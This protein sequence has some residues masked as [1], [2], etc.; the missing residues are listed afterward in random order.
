MQ[1]RGERRVSHF[2]SLKRDFGC[3]L[4]PKR[5][6]LEERKSARGRGMKR[7][8]GSVDAITLCSLGYANAL[9]T[10][11]KKKRSNERPPYTSP[12][13]YISDSQRSEERKQHAE[14]ARLES[15][16]YHKERDRKRKLAALPVKVSPSPLEPLSVPRLFPSA[17]PLLLSLFHS[18]NHQSS[19]HFCPIFRLHLP[20]SLFH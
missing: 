4:V 5:I 20:N 7:E 14:D 11:N 10:N 1:I 6:Q 9:I 3:T 16:L 15:N 13:P 2:C 12:C 18:S 8:E 17:S 19:P